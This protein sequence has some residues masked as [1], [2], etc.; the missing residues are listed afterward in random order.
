MFVLAEL[1]FL[2]HTDH[3]NRAR[4]TSRLNVTRLEME[5]KRT[6]DA[7]QQMHIEVDM[8]QERLQLQLQLLKSQIACESQSLKST[9]TEIQRPACLIGALGKDVKLEERPATVDN[10]VPTTDVSFPCVAAFVTE[11]NIYCTDAQAHR[12]R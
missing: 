1:A 4:F 6:K 9:T 7:T 5:A 10:A 8:W 11:R 12:A 3:N 2:R